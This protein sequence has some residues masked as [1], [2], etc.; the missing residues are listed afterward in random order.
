MNVITTH[1]TDSP[2][3]T[4][5]NSTF[6]TASITPPA[7]QLIV[8]TIAE[9]MASGTQAQPSVSGCGLTWDL[10]GTKVNVSNTSQRISM[11]RARGI[12]TAGAL[13][14]NCGSTIT[15]LMY[16]VDAFQY[17]DRSGSNGSGAVP[18][19]VSDSQG[20]ADPMSSTLTFAAFGNANNAT[21]CAWIGPDGETTPS[22]FSLVFSRSQDLGPDNNFRVFFKN[23]SSSTVTTTS[24]GGGANVATGC[25]IE[26]K[27]RRGGG[28]FLR[29]R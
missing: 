1:L 5:G 3:D 24:T 26:I 8:I 28:A 6:T 10:I 18:Q 16:S 22:G 17:V 21:F 27:F 15:S 23:S 13:T 19:F 2:Q 4:G 9:D 11:F 12:P 20:S 25:G 29:N 7:G 14:I